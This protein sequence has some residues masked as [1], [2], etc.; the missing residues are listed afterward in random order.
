[1]KWSIASS[2]MCLKYRPNKPGSNLTAR[3]ARALLFEGT[4]KSTLTE[5]LLAKSQDSG[6]CRVFI[7]SLTPSG[8]AQMWNGTRVEQAHRIAYREAK[9]TIPDG[10]DIDH[11]CKNRACINPDHLEAVPH[12]VNMERAVNANREKKSCKRGHALSGDNVYLEKYGA[13]RCIACRNA[14][15]VSA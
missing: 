8:Y 6:E 4:M 9:G 10:Y 14:R 5:R 7:R 1:M 12:S 13:R 3:R 2:T 15:R 11:L